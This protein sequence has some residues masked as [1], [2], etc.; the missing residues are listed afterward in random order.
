MDE[1]RRSRVKVV[2]R[3]IP[4]GDGVE[5]VAELPLGRGQRQR[6]AGE[7]TGAE[8]AVRCGLGRRCEPPQVA[9]QHLH[10]REQVMAD[11]H[12]LCALKMRVPRHRRL[13]LGLCP[14]ERRPGQ[15]R[16]RGAGFGARVDDVEPER[17]RHLI[18]AGPTRVNLP[19]HLAEQP[20]DRAVDV[21]VVGT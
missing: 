10:P 9:L 14:V 11:G 19:P 2:E 8:R 16:D 4:V 3:K 13:G 20:L 15:R 17:G 7:R 6:R 1:A 21:L 12:R 5:R 18:V